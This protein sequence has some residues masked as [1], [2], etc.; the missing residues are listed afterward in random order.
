M[1]EEKKTAPSSIV[2]KVEKSDKAYKKNV[3]KK[4][5]KLVKAYNKSKFYSPFAFAI[6]M[7]TDGQRP[8][9]NDISDDDQQAIIGISRAVEEF[10]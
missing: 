5:K 6:D 2:D 3:P 8:E 7:V 10:A 4:V 1:A 9:W